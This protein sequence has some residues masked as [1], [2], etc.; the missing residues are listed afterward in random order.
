M[1]RLISKLSLALC[2]TSSMMWTL[3]CDSDDGGDGSSDGSGGSGG[4]GG[5]SADNVAACNNW[6]DAFN[7]GDIDISGSVDCSDFE[8]TDECD[9]TPY[10]DCLTDNTECVDGIPDLS[11]WDQCYSLLEC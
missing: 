10:F 3:G 11:G 6:V 9:L 7:C 4:D 1:V 8:G 2:L 5:G